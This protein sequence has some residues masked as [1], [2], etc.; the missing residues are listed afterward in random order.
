MKYERIQ[1]E[2]LFYKTKEEL[3]KTLSTYSGDGIKP[4]DS[5]LT[6]LLSHFDKGLRGELTSSYYLS[7]IDPGIGKTESYCSFIKSCKEMGFFPEGSILVAVATLEEISSMVLRCG[8]AKD[9]YA[10]LTGDGGINAMGRGE[11]RI[12]GARVLFTTQAMIRSRTAG[13]SFASTKDFHYE[14]A[15]RTL[16]IWDEGF[17]LAKGVTLSMHDLTGLSRSVRSSNPGLLACIDALATQMVV[18]AA[19][20]QIAIPCEIATLARTAECGK[21]LPAAC[22]KTL[23]DLVSVA[24]TVMVL[25]TLGGVVG[26]VLVGASAALPTDFAPVIILDASGRV[27]GTYK[28]HKAGIGN[29]VRLTSSV[30]D[31]ANVCVHVCKAAVGKDALADNDYRD[32]IYRASA[33]IIDS[34]PHE[35]W[36]VISYKSCSEFDV[37]NEI[38]HYVANPS[39][40]RFVNWGRHHGTNEFR[41]CK[42]ILVIGSNLYGPDGYHALELGAS[43]LPTDKFASPT[44]EFAGDE[45]CNNILQAIMRGNARRGIGNIAGACEVYWFASRTP[46][47]IAAVT[48]AFPNCDVQEWNALNRPVNNSANKVLNYIQD[49]FSVSGARSLTKADVRKA[50]GIKSAS[51]FSRI[52]NKPLFI[53]QLS[54]KS[55]GMTNKEFVRLS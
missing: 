14:G 52:I 54:R 32:Q 16:R 42:N 22:K 46:D 7:S 31:Y 36:L 3:Q 20:D 33:K 28:S 9:D 51:S 45:L 43:G 19:G 53:D 35:R 25:R 50:I 55:F 5:G 47:P 38:K 10:C 4:L 37:E 15:P 39:N 11:A 24:G 44:K 49:Y 48:K 23:S 8:L 41:D 18:R 27:R 17:V 2:R 26:S 40:I 1:I 12:S 13:K 6:D 30:R 29:L 34:K 21:P